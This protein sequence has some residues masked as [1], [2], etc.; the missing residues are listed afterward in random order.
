VV[1]SLVYLALCR[2]L[3]L[4]VSCWRHDV[5]KDV[6]LVVLRHQVRVLE[7]QLHSRVRY[8]PAD[9]AVFAALSRLLPPGTLARVPRYAGYA[10]PLA[11]RGREA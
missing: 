7:R 8:R 2:V 9:R 3:A 1:F 6:E 10:A 11:Q 4:V 5:D